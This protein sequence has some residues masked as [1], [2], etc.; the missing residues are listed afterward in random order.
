M[1]KKVSISKVNSISA[2]ITR[3]FTSRDPSV[4]LTLW[5][6]LVLPHLDYCSQLWAP[7]KRGDIQKLEMLQKSFL[8]KINGVKHLNYWE[9]LKHLKLYSLERRRERYRILYT[10]YIIEGIVPNFNNNNGGGITYYINQRLGRKCHLKAVNSGPNKRIWRGSLSEEGPKLFNVLPKNLRN[11]TKCTKDYFKKNLDQ[12][13]SHI[14]DE[15][16]VQNY[17]TMRRADSNSLVD[18]VKLRI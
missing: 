9:Q 13:L 6:S 11:M 8:R 5:K 14:P 2:W 1:L 12:F 10:W 18:M 16:L 7:A 4:M 3:V 15:P 17:V